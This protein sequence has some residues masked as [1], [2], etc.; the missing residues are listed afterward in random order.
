MPL[1]PLLQHVYNHGS[2]EVIRRGKAIF[3]AGGAALQDHDP[4]LEQIRFRVRN[5]QYHTHYVVTVQKYATPKSLSVRCQCP[6]NL[7]DICRHGVAALLQ[8]NE[9]EGTG[10][11]QAAPQVYNQAQTTVRLRPVSEA[12]LS[13]YATADD[14]KTAGE[15]AAARAVTIVRDDDGARVE[16]RIT[17]GG[18]PHEISLRRGE[19]SYWDTSCTCDETAR[20]LCCHKAAVFLQLL[21]LH[22]PKHFEVRRPVSEQKVRLLAQYGFGP[23]DDLIG[24]FAFTEESGKLFLRVLDPS[25]KKLSEAVKATPVADAVDTAVAP[26]IPQALG[27]VLDA[28][29]PTYPGLDAVLISGEAT[30]DG[31]NFAGAVARLAAGAP[32]A[33]EDDALVA[34]V[35]KL[36]PEAIFKYLRKVLPLVEYYDDPATILTAA[37]PPEVCE[38]VWDYLQPKWSRLLALCADRPLTFLKPTGSLSAASLEPVLT[39]DEPAAVQLRVARAADGSY[40][41]QAEYLLGGVAVR[42]R[43]VLLL[44]GGA[45]LVSGGRAYAVDT[46]AEAVL[47]DRLGPDGKRMIAA[48]EWPGILS[49][50]IIPMAAHLPVQFESG[51]AVREE[52][53]SP[54][55][56]LR[57]EERDSGQLLF[58]P[59]FSYSGI[60][61]TA[62]GRGDA[63][64]AAGATVRIIPRNAEAE[65]EALHTVHTLHTDMSYS[66]SGGFF[67]LPAAQ[68]VAGGWFFQALDS[69]KSRGIGLTGYEGLRALRINTHRPDTRLRVSSGID[70]FDAELDVYFGDQRATVAEVK[71]SLAAGEPG[72]RLPDGSLGL[73]PEAWLEKYRLLLKVGEARGGSL[74]LKKVHFGVLDALL[75]EVDEQA[76]LDELE[77]K[78]ARL[79]DV[80]DSERDWSSAPPPAD[81][82][83]ELRPYQHAGYQW[84]LF[85]KETG[86]GGILADD[87]GLG[88][89]VQAL[90]LLQ[91]L[92]DEDSEAKALVVCPATLLYN[93]EAEAGRFTPGLRVCIHHGPKRATAQKAFAACDIVV[94]TY[95]TLR[96][97]ARWLRERVW[98]CAVLDESQAIKNPQSQAAKA[99]QT[100]QAAHRLALSGTPVQNNTFDLYAQMQFL[101]PGLLGSRERFA[102]EFATPIDKFG[103]EGA[104]AD[105]RRLVRPFMLRRTK[106][107]VA[108]DLP[109]KTESLRWCDMGPEQRRIYDAYRLDYRDRLLGLIDTQGIDRSQFHILQ[110]LTKLRQI[111]DSPS[112]LTGAGEQYGV[113]SVKLDEIIRELQENVG[114]HKV[115]VFSQFLGML[116]LLR[117]RLS[118]AG[119][120]HAYFDGSYAAAAREA[121]VRRFSDDPACRV[122]LISLKAGGTGLNLTAADYVYLVDP[123]WNPAVEQQA[124]DRTHRIGQTK[125]V[126]AY[127]TVCRDS[128][129]EKMLLLQEKKR[130]LAAELVSGD[131]GAFLKRLTREDV[132][133]LLG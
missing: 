129:E 85:L 91:H 110:G 63:L 41:L 60:P 16:A 21:R 11:F 102:A 32:V 76:V 122:F 125:P 42:R 54:T 97:D 120:G 37:P 53:V 22:G 34:L 19:E 35:E 36:R 96:S 74:R 30:A 66:E 7:G 133:F 20:P 69:L 130:A 56:T 106:E 121:E 89:T 1:P 18:G 61:V 79:A 112:L 52:G 26:S 71:K 114:G 100:L 107:D 87:M 80:L 75:A 108:K 39:A 131:D 10:F 128:I 6:Y 31:S 51:I 84:L 116:A 92:K 77:D 82:K 55:L 43:D 109:A 81:L 9:L 68:V 57:L 62:G 64:A 119:I 45:L 88:K 111:C 40:T 13:I 25:I 70:W 99:A 38:A 49:S 115:L 83:A 12:V 33:G 4:L 28:G 95:G 23:A 27:V 124:I 5:D 117:G 132:A 3:S 15:W 86:W 78:K 65:R 104:K 47:L 50:E 29:A 14:L 90:A 72:V 67:H 59:V 73:L 113:H 58:H 127:R 103:D 105:L 118:E 94:T 24:K 48:E 44:A 46:P 98:S 17:E 2:D 126:F 8:L 93:W 101:N 123:W